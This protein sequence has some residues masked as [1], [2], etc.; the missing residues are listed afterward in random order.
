MSEVRKIRTELQLLIEQEEAIAVLEEVQ[1]VL[2]E[3]SARKSDFW[4]ELSEEDKASLEAGIAD[5]EAGR[6]KTWEEVKK[7]LIAKHFDGEEQK[8]R[9][10]VTKLNAE[11]SSFA[12]LADEED[13]YSLDDLKE[14]Y[15]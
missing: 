12:F 10:T 6:V 14:R 2:S 7:D 8:F 4:D 5:A 15:R 11:S 13:L 3:S 9:E 1:R